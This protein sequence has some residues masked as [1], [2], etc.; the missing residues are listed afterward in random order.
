MDKVTL[1]Q[2]E[3]RVLDHIREYIASHQVSPTIAELAE[4]LGHRSRGTVHRYVHS[5]I[6]K[7]RLERQGTGWRGLRLAPNA[8]CPA[9][10]HPADVKRTDICR[11]ESAAAQHSPTVPL[12]TIPLLGTIAAGMPIEAI[13]DEDHLDLAA[14]FIGPDRYALRVTGSSMMD[15]G[16]LDGDT[17]IIRKLSRARTG[18][19]IV[20]LIDGH[21]ATLKRLGEYSSQV[22]EL[23]AENR[24]IP[25]MRYSAFRVAIQGVLIGQLRS[26]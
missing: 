16:I 18:D 24:E 7:G 19:I 10:V 4:S 17:V 2:L 23:I 6:D 1:T 22:V 21:E 26:Y 5:L 12:S 15:V 13:P 25:P 8:Q 20:A 14:F 3:H 11:D 9:D